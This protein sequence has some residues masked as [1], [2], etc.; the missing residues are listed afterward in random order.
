MKVG[1]PAAHLDTCHEFIGMKG[2]RYVVMGSGSK[3][4]YYF[5]F[6]GVA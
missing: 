1:D 6:I 5:F 2:L 4:F 3:S